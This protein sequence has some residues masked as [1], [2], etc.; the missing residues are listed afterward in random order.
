MEETHDGEFGDDSDDEGE[1]L[2]EES[3]SEDL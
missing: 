3:D 1:D 2:G